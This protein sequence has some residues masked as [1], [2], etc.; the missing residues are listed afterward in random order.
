MSNCEDTVYHDYALEDDKE[1]KIQGRYAVTKQKTSDK[2]T[3]YTVHTLGDFYGCIFKNNE[4][5]KYH[6][7]FGPEENNSKKFKKDWFSHPVDTFRGAF[8]L[9][10]AKSGYKLVGSPY[11]QIVIRKN[12][13]VYGLIP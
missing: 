9:L 2:I 13:S 12:I 7:Y 8:D 4:D 1:S 3:F 10:T 5:G 6:A 11:K